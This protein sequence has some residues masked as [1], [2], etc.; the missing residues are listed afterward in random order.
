[1]ISGEQE[2]LLQLG[3]QTLGGEKESSYP[4]GIHQDIHKY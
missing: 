2:S 4:Q 1:M 3:P